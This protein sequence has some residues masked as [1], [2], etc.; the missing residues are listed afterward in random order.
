MARRF[1]AKVFLNR[2]TKT[3]LRRSFVERSHAGRLE[4]SE[5][6]SAITD[7]VTLP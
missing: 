6:V 3:L 5:S 1:A 7:G 2:H 4:L